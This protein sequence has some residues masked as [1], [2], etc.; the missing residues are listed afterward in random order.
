MKKNFSNTEKNE[1]KAGVNLRICHIRQSFFDDNNRN[2]ANAIGIAEQNLSHICSGNRYAGLDVV[3][4]I[5]Y[6]LPSIDGNWLITGIGQ[7]TRQELTPQQPTTTDNADNLPPATDTA[8]L[9]GQIQLLKEQLADKDSRIEN[10]TA[11]TAVLKH[12]LSQYLATKGARSSS[13]TTSEIST[14]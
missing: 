9:Q 3:A 12:Q 13:P 7:M 5:L 1:K 14:L 11:Y 10:L 2:F 6:T 4:R 8:A